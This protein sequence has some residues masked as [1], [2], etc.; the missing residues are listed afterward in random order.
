MAEPRC[1]AIGHFPFSVRPAFSSD[2][3]LIRCNRRQMRK[4][5]AAAAPNAEPERLRR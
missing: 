2:G 5:A 4:T 3:L 1:F